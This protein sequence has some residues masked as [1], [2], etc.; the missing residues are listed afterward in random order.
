[1]LPEVGQ[2]LGPYEILG[3]LGGGGMGH[4]FRAWDQRLQ[5]DVAVKLLNDDYTMPGMRERFLQEA[6][7]ASALNHPNICTVFDIGEQDRNPYLV[8]ELLEGETLKE[9]IERGALSAEEIV[10][11]AMEIADALTAA[12]NKGIVHRDIKPA[13]IFLVGM[14]N[15]KRQAKVLDF[16]LAKIDFDARSRETRALGLTLAGSTVGTLSY[17]SPEQARGEFLDAR[18]DLFSLGIVLY[19]MAT[20]QVP[21]KGATSAVM[22]L[23]LFSHNPE[24]IRNWNESIPRALEKA[25]FKLLEKNQKKRF[26]TAKELQDVL[27]KIGDKLERRGWAGKGPSPVVPLVRASDP[28][29][30]YRG[31]RRGQSQILVSGS[32]PSTLVARP[33]RSPDRD[34]GVEVTA[35]RFLRSSVVTVASGEVP[36]QLSGVQASMTGARF[37]RAAARRQPALSGLSASITQFEYGVDDFEVPPMESVVEEEKVQELLAASSKVSS[38]TQ[39]RMVVGATMILAG[40]IVVALVCSGM[41]RPL[42]LSP[43]DHLLLTVIENKT[44]DKTLDS[45]VM[46]GIELALQ[47]SRS[48]NVLGGEAYRAGLRQI[49]VEHAASTEMA[50]EQKVA[51]D[52]GA[53]AYLYGEIK[54]AKAPYTISVDVLKSDSNDKVETVEEKVSRREEIPAAIG[55][56]AQDIRSRISA[57][58]RAEERMSVALEKEAT[59]NLDALHAYAVGEAARESGRTGDALKAY[60]EAVTLDPKFAQAQIRLA[61]LYDTE[62]SEVAS[63]NASEMARSAATKASDKVKLLAQFCYEMNVTGDEDR[64]L[65]IIREYVARYPLDSEGMK[66][67]ARGLRAEGNLPDALRAA[68]QGLVENPFDAEV[69]SEAELTMIGMDRYEGALQLEGQAE[70]VGV[71]PS[72]NALIAGYLAA[73]EDVVAKEGNAMQVAVGEMEAAPGAR[74]TF[75]QLYRY[76]LYL[77]NTGK[78]EE[79]LELWKKASARAGNVPEFASTRAAMLAQGALDRALM[80]KC[81]VALELVDELKGLPKGPTT[82]FNAGMAA[83]LCGDQSYAADV[84]AGL[85]RDY[86]KNTAVEQYFVP[87]LQAAAEIGASEPE[88]ALDSLIALE[89]YDQMSLSAYLRGMANAALGQTSAAVQDFQTVLAHRG[90]DLTL[91]SNAYPMAEIGVARAYAMKRDKAARTDAYQRFLMLWRDADQDQPLI[92]EASAKGKKSIARPT[93]PL[94]VVK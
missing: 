18:S 61:W 67:L 47:Q 20:R 42:V 75:A 26:Q 32:K 88:K 85:Q 37:A 23:Q 57:D 72:V 39:L 2:R 63:A 36:A 60:R 69:Y 45:T 55:R 25:I 4:V 10:R 17:M 48:L 28:V 64:A 77:D 86:P 21:F 71:A 5:R 40:V 82:S 62:K 19:E 83:A 7:A 73:K 8:M 6:R 68:E 3:R 22:F 53:R 24:P 34:P 78:M 27:A 65:E 81:T 46:E 87:Q 44:G 80:E 50:P 74:M 11:Y 70:R 90:V 33:V 56:L 76:G 84:V 94:A 93:S 16:G 79:G 13:N 66:G 29:A 43:N 58:E 12:H 51:L 52:V 30:M 41:F 14:P 9:R 15:E 38:R 35:M 49:E 54:G 1:M 59:G 92:A 91:G 31:Q 89:D